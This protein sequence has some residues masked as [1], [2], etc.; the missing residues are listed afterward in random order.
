GD[1]LVRCLRALGTPV[2]VQN[3]IDDTG[4]QVADVVVGFVDIE[5]RSPAEVAAI[6][7]PFDHYCWDLYS[8]VGAWYEA[9][10]ARQARRRETLH[11]LEA[12]AGARAEIGRRAARRVPSCH[13]ATMA[14]LGSGYDRLTHERDILA[15][16]FFHVAVERLK[17]TGAV[18]LET[19]GKNAGCWVMPLEGTAEFAGLEDPDK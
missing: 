7:E 15:L 8:R 17:A 3:Y 1:T 2:E 13:P 6:P 4:V 19:E 9:D 18:K 5:G 11:E 12:G 16:D 10:P 14:R